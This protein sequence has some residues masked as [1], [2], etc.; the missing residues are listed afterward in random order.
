M[1]VRSGKFLRRQEG[2]ERDKILNDS[3][4]MV[5]R[6]KF[7]PIKT[8]WLIRYRAGKRELKEFP[9]WPCPKELPFSFHNWDH[10][11][12]NNASLLLAIVRVITVQLLVQPT[13]LS[14]SILIVFILYDF[15][16][17]WYS[18]HHKS[19]ACAVL[20]LISIMSWMLQ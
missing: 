3:R 6:V 19:L 5:G 18:K 11:F 15:Q 7:S 1:F 4:Y 8:S 14:D 12:Q 9:S 2:K 13:D 20:I 16:K 17:E 10:E